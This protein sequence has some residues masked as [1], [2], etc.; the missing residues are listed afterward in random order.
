MAIS[1]KGSQMIIEEAK[2]LWNSVQLLSEDEIGLTCLCTDIVKA[3]L[4]KKTEL[5]VENLPDSVR[6]IIL[7]GGFTISVMNRCSD[8][9]IITE[10][11]GWAHNK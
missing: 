2:Q 7:A 8:N 6:E 3:I 5:Q 9:E 11:S 10:I 4:L 1:K